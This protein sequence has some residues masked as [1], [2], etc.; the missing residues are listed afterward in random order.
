MVFSLSTLKIN[1]HPFIPAPTL[2]GRDKAEKPGI[3]S[4]KTPQLPQYFHIIY[5]KN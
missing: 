1:P 2:G 5:S 4:V 3:A